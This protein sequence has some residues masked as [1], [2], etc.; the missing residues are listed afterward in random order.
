MKYNNLYE[1]NLE[2]I[3]TRAEME[4]AKNGMAYNDKRKYLKRLEKEK[5]ILKRRKNNV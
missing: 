1:Y 2:I 4:N 5:A 3:K